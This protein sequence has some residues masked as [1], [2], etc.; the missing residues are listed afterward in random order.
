MLCNVFLVFLH[1]RFFEFVMHD[2]IGKLETIDKKA[3]IWKT[4]VKSF[5]GN[6]SLE[7]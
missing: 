5:L 4:V 6:S 1:V 7:K 3:K 2:I